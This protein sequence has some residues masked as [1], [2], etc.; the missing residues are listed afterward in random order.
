MNRTFK[1]LWNVVRGQY[2]VVNE[3]AGDAQSRGSG[4][5]KRSGTTGYGGSGF[6]LAALAMAIAAGFSLP[7]QAEDLY[8]DS[9]RGTVERTLSEGTY[10]YGT[11]QLYL[12]DKSL[13]TAEPNVGRDV[14]ACIEFLLKNVQS[15]LNI[16]GA[17]VTTN[18]FYL[19]TMGPRIYGSPYW[20]FNLPVKFQMQSGSLNVTGQAQIEG[21]SY[22]QT[23]G[24][25]VMNAATIYT[26][27]GGKRTGA[28]TDGT[29][30]FSG[31]TLSINSL[32]F[33]SASANIDHTG[34]ELT[35][36]AFDSTSNTN[37]TVKTTG[38]KV[39]FGELSSYGKLVATNADVYAP[40]ISLT[41]QSYTSTDSNLTTGLDQVADLKQM[42]AQ[43]RVLV[44]ANQDEQKDVDAAVL[45]DRMAVT[46]LLEQFENNVTWSGGKFHFTGSYSQSIADK[47]TELIHTAFGDDVVVEFEETTPDI[48]PPSV[49]NGLTAALSNAIISANTMSGGAVFTEYDLDAVDVANT[50]GGAAG[51]Y[52][53][54]TSVG[55]RSVNGDKTVTVTGG[56][57]FA[58]LGE[59][60]GS[61]V[62]SGTLIADNGTLRLGT[63]NTGVT[64]GG[65]VTD[66]DLLNNGVLKVDRGEF[67]VKDVA[68]DGSV[69][70]AAGDLTFEKLDITGSFTNAG[71]ATLADGAKWTGGA[72][73]G[74]LNSKGSTIGG[75]FSNAGG[76]WNLDGKLSFAEDAQVA[77]ATGTLNTDFRNLFDNGTG[78]ELDGLNTVSLNATMPEEVRTI[79]TELFTK[80]VKGTV[81][82]DVLAHMTFDGAG[83]LVITNANLTTTQR[84]DLTKAFQDAFGTSTTIKF[85]GTIEGVSEDSVLNTAK[86]N[87]LAD[88]GFKDIVYI[89]RALQGEAGDVTIGDAGV[90]DSVGFMSIEDAQSVT[91]T[92]GKKLV[93]VGQKDQA[94]FKLVESDQAVKV[95]GDGELVLGSL[96]LEGSE[97]YK[98]TVTAVNVGDDAAGGKFTTVA[99]DY[100]V[101]TLEAKHKDT[102]VS[103]TKDGIL[104]VGALAASS[105]ASVVND[106]TLKVSGDATSTAAS[107][108]NRADMTVEG[109]LTTTGTLTNEKTL[110]V[111]NGLAAEGTMTNAKGGVLDVEGNVTV[112]S[113]GTPGSFTNAGTA[114]LKGDLSVSG[115][116]TNNADAFLE[117]NTMTVVGTL[118]NH[119]DI[120]ASDDSEVYGTLT[121]TGTIDLF[122]TV[123][124]QRGEINNTHSITGQGTITVN[125]LLANV[126]N[127]DF[128]GETLVLTNT[129]AGSQEVGTLANGVATV[130][131]KGEMTFDSITVGAGTEFYNEGTFT[132][133]ELTVEEGGYHFTGTRPTT[134]GIALFA[135]EGATESYRTMTVAG[136]TTNAGNAYYGTLTI[137]GT[138]IYTNAATGALFTGESDMHLD[139]TGLTIEA[140]GTLENAGTATL[141]SSLTN[142]GTI[143]GDGTVTFKRGGT[144]TNVF[145]NTGTISV[146]TFATDGAITYNQSGAAS[147]FEASNGWFTNATVNVEQGEMSHA[148]AGTGN[149]YN[150]G[151]EGA[152]AAETA[153]ITF[154]T[155]DSSNVFNI[156]EGATLDVDTIA[157][158]EAD[159]TVHLLGGTL[160]TTLDQIFGDLR[161]TAA[162]IDAESP[163]DLVDVDGVK[164]VTGVGDIKAPVAQG[165]EF[166]WGTVAF[167]DAVYST[168]LVSDVLTKLDQNDTAIPGHEGVGV[169]GG[170]EVAFNGA[171][172]ET[173]NVDLA[174]KVTARPAG[175][176]EP[177]GSAFAVFTGEL[178]TN[179]TQANGDAGGKLY[180]GDAGK[181]SDANVLDNSMGFK[182]VEGVTGG[183][184]VADGHHFVLV[185]ELASK[186]GDYALVDGKVTVDTDGVLTLGSY[187]TAEKT[188]G[189]L[190][191][192]TVT[193]G[194]VRVRHGDFT[195]DTVENAGSI[196]IGGDGQ[197]LRA[198]TDVSLTVDKY[199]AKAN[200]ELKNYGTFNA[201]ELTSDENAGTITN[202]GLLDVAT[203]TISTALTN[204][205]TAVFDTL[206]ITGNVVTNGAQDGSNEGV[207]LE[208]G[209][210]T[211]ANGSTLRNYAALTAGD[212]TID[213]RVE[214]AAGA[215]LDF[216]SLEVTTNGLLA[217]AGT[218]TTDSITQTG[219]QVQ[220]GG[221]MTVESTAA[222]Q[223]AGVFNNTGTLAIE[224]GEAFTIAEGGSFS[225]AGTMTSEADV[226]VTGGAFSQES[227]TATALVNM[228]VTGGTTTVSA[229]KTLAGSGLFT[230]NAVADAEAVKNDGTIDFA[231]ITV[232]QGKV[233]GDGTFGS[234]DTAEMKVE[235]NGVVDQG[236]V[237]ANY[238][239]NAGIVTAGSMQLGVPS[240][241]NGTMTIEEKLDGRITNNGT[242]TLGG[243]EE[244]FV[245]TS[246]LITNNGTLI[247]SETVTLQGGNITQQADTA[248]VFKDLVIESGRLSVRVL[249]SSVQGE[250]LTVNGASADG[251]YVHNEG[252]VDFDV[253]NVTKGSVTGE[254]TLGVSD[255][256]ITVAADG[257]VDQAKVEGDTLSN[258]GSVVADELLVHTEGSNTGLLDAIVAH[259]GE[260]FEN[261]ADAAMTVAD[262]LTGN[263]TNKGALTFEGENGLS[264]TSGTLTNNGT[265]SATEAVTVAGGNLVHDSDVTATFTDLTI[266]SGSLVNN[267]DRTMEGA[268]LRVEAAD[269]ATNLVTNDGTLDFGNI[270]VAKGGLVGSGTL[271]SSDSTILTGVGGRIEQGNVIA[272]T[273][274]NLGSIS[275][276]VT[277]DNGTNLGVIAANDFTS[278]GENANF[279]NTGT[280]TVAGKANVSGFENHMNAAF[281]QGATFTGTNLSDGT[282]T[283][284][285]GLLDVKDGQ[286]TIAGGTLTVQNGAS[287]AGVLDVQE[288]VTAD[289]KDGLTIVNGGTFATAGNTT[290]DQITS[291]TTGTLVAAGGSLTIGDLTTASGMTFTQTADTTLEVGKGW[292]ENSVINIQ[293]GKFDASL[294]KDDEGNASGML[295]HN[296]VNIGKT[297]LPAVV[298]PDSYLPAADK[299]DW[300]DPYVT[301]KVDT[302]TSDTV[303][304]VGSGGVLDV[305]HIELTPE[306]GSGTTVTIGTGGG[307]QTSL[308]Q[309]F[310]KVATTVTDIEAI[311][312]ETGKVDIVTDVIATTTVTD[313]KDSVQAGLTFE[314]GSMVAWDDEDW[315]IDLVSSVANSLTNA[316]L[317]SDEVRVQQHFLGDFMGDFTV[318][319][320]HRLEEEQLAMGNSHVLDPGVVFDTT[321]LHNVTEADQ[322]A[323][324]GLVIGMTQDEAGEGMNGI[325]Y[326][327]GFK[328]VANA[329]TVAIVNGKEFVLVGTTRP[330]DF[331][332]TTGYTDDNKLLLDS[333]DGGS[334]SVENGT[335]TLGSNGVTNATVGWVNAATVAADGSLV[336][337]NGEFAVWDI[338]NEGKVDVTTG[339]VLHT[340]NLVNENGETHVGGGLTAGSFDNDSGRLEIA[341]GG[342]ADI[343]TLESGTMASVIEN[344]GT[345]VVGEVANGMLAGTIANKGEDS[346]LSIGSDVTIAGWESNEG[347]AFWQ[348]VTLQLGT[349][350]NSGY[351]QGKFLTVSSGTTH[352]NTGTSIWEGMKVDGTSVNGEAITD[353][354]LGWMEGFKPGAQMQVGT[355]DGTGTF[356]VNGS[357][358]NNGLLDAV[359]VENTLVNGTMTNSGQA[360]YDDMTISANGTST[361]AGY[362][363][364]DILT[365][366]GE[367]SNTGVSV[368]NNVTIAQNASSSNGED[369]GDKPNGNEE[370]FT[371]DSVVYVGS[372]AADETFTIDGS[373]V[374]NGIVQAENAEN[375]NVGGTLVNNGQAAYDDMTIGKDG[376]STNVGYEQGDI[377]TVEGSHD[378]T[379]T[380]VWNNVTIA[381][382]GTGSNGFDLGDGPKGDEEG[383]ESDSVLVVGSE[384]VP[385]SLVIE[386]DYV[387][388]GILQAENVSTTDVSGNLT[389]NGQAVYDD[390][391]VNAGGSSVNTG[392]EQGDILTVDGSHENSGT[393]IWNNVTIGTG[394]SGVNGEEL[395]DGPKGHEEGF[396]SDDV[397]VIGS[398]KTDDKF[399]V[400]GD[401]ANH[402]VLDATKTEDTTVTGSLV[403]DGQAH[404]DDMDVVNGGSSDNDGYEKGDILTVGDG[405][406]HTNDGTSIWNN[407]TIGQG[408]SGSNAG[409][410]QIG[411]EGGGDEF[412]VEGDYTNDGSLDATDSE[413]TEVT[414]DLDNNGD[415]H[416]D[417]MDIESGG[418]STNDNYEEGDI[419]DVNEGGTW[420]QNG[421]SHWNN[422]NV[423]GGD[424]DNSG[425]IDV[426]DKIVI[427]DGSDFTNT[428]DITTGELVVD[429][430]VVDIGGGSIDADKTTV[431]GGDIIVGNHKDLSDENRVDFD[432]I[433]DGD[434]NGH[435]WVIGNGDLSFG[436]GADEFADKIGAPDIPEAPSRITVTQNVTVGDTGSIAVGSDVWT[437]ESN[438]EDVGDG[439][440]FF[441][442]DSVTVVDSTILEDGKAAFTG[443]K[444]GATVTVE[445]GA[446]L[447]LGNLDVAG[448]YLITDG[449][450]TAGNLGEADEW[451]GGW[452]GAIWAPTDAGSGLDWVLTLGWDDTKLWVNAKL[453]SVIN[454][455]PDIAIPDNI[456]ESLENC[457]NAGG[458]DDVLVCT[459]IRNPDLSKDDKT[460]ILNSVAEIGH[461]AGAAAMAF[462]EATQAVDSL[463]GRVS[464][465]SEAYNTDGSMKSGTKG[466]ALWVDV[467]G[468][469]TTADSYGATG[470]VTTGYDADSYG[471]IMGADHKLQS[472]NV[473]LGAAFSYTDGSLDSTGDLLPT[474]NDFSTWGIHAYGAW[475]PSER[476]NVIGT[477]S[478][479]RSAS[480]AV[481]GLPAEAGFSKAEADID[482][483][484]FVAGVRGEAIFEVGKA[485]FIP[486]AGLRMVVTDTKG[487]KTKLDGQTAYRNEADTATTFQMPIGVSMRFDH[488]TESG[489]TI[490]PSGDITLT[491][492]FGDTEQDTKVKGTGG[493][494][495]TVTGEFT[496]NF[497]A[498]FSLGLQAESSSNTT[499]GVR[500][501]LTAGQEG[502]QDH[503]LKLEF[504]K[505]F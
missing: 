237:I 150:L 39:T 267:G 431:N 381:Q 175:T 52:N 37:G 394:G 317:I 329:D 111:K 410:I 164:V 184:T 400:D 396:T 120:D 85:V 200:S 494:T 484:L 21:D 233:V 324:T 38:S 248:A 136:Q 100:A 367:H 419:L 160:S 266:N 297:D 353:G 278:T 130:E 275:G 417:D 11:I 208:A 131:N 186:Q 422:I 6:K 166:G 462:N 133:G 322:Y 268:N 277:V 321:T 378:N 408:G 403:N 59:G 262:T 157:L 227:D 414:G 362:E 386:G 127:A 434:L 283:V 4:K 171:A 451:L 173:F 176:D 441:A 457:R 124:G 337:K 5:L 108:Q 210:L 168:G 388:N 1:T 30:H 180:V 2:V 375:T 91:V 99:G 63:T 296:T 358:T 119:G 146:G 32:K 226:N 504:R 35:I 194:T 442:H 416:Y 211:T 465:R 121:N 415:A 94:D 280:L 253:I 47:A 363:Q 89:D 215:T 502:K 147:S 427:G 196:T 342:S 17:D 383:F 22:F 493:A 145:E 505:L 238:L 185:G 299:V 402:G 122:N 466:T 67:V 77:N 24:D 143:R 113:A 9:R 153:T 55:F 202:Y 306:D 467:L 420:D 134:T 405:S 285:G 264:F 368:W 274:T 189:D 64:V 428:G 123:V 263:L 191:D 125:G 246:G 293:G 302:I 487:Y 257:K 339:S 313:V 449:F 117:T 204:L 36:G 101:T 75:S 177:F 182:G 397:V 214:N 294:I 231:N 60:S 72:N 106:G 229:G 382:G 340:N 464:M 501:G 162:D 350:T 495:D 62:A 486:H 473:I 309:F 468:S 385:G 481:Q 349:M 440:L 361:N 384:E 345:L 418:T 326:S 45:G 205:K 435:Y 354:V 61:T 12:S 66:V 198:D 281:E 132:G 33:S 154:N 13:Q 181:V 470:S 240:G 54:D 44:M 351:E 380:S 10:D 232:S 167:D 325:D 16:T 250:T 103:V 499:V 163:D 83:N 311:D 471:F 109:K 126:E 74:T 295:G 25:V 8:L 265:L 228:N 212:A 496:G 446:Q 370:G 76:T 304:N 474:S 249:N 338:A 34:G 379:G 272:N 29:M 142:A 271:G 319:T 241:N 327:I 305:D 453:E 330:D 73:T 273:I 423:N 236:A 80:Y 19:Y 352:T 426:D 82:E 347:T 429:G 447:V 289:I 374:N 223:I 276:N 498:T 92:D 170:L 87:T 183:M 102:L 328:N 20:Y 469:W 97:T 308:D 424:V 476:T 452:D 81:K 364:G 323:N 279:V 243:G 46:K 152:S 376:S 86:V 316:G 425:T 443:T 95:T 151:K 460:R 320:A 244:G 221:D 459:V 187:A 389:N 84:D 343:G 169:D 68:G 247:G 258:A 392:Y 49:V 390:M 192:L 141:A 207:T 430:G 50:V 483:N 372:E 224:A 344:E 217:N 230:V 348:N 137:T 220:Q 56:K 401:Y 245:F 156:Y 3:K 193:D 458:A 158:T 433:L 373:Y 269:G 290:I 432:T 480:E 7:V 14:Q 42:I 40:K 213:G 88:A 270:A 174:N 399:N 307:I 359:W 333:T 149:V 371:S 225:N 201:T 79:L 254:G 491:P 148:T 332:W 341:Q 203:A 336:T 436:E 377:L 360:T 129:A 438:H 412:T 261:A 454:E 172:S 98:G 206:G 404:Y 104:T 252:L 411:G 71:T 485:K 475:K 421:E 318:D 439:N 242:M 331:D 300:S 406:T 255:S 235:K 463:E 216:G 398:D 314:D 355:E 456:D 391:D 365:V 492:Q 118:D 251:Q 26:P 114:T 138:G 488:V 90:R 395:G 78:A 315:S 222:S 490:R 70:V 116:L 413:N 161:Y 287:V 139:G 445:E 135:N 369:L 69:N 478:Y 144:G 31:G 500:Y 291:A 489:W 393:S 497:A 195:A 334:V 259:V 23:G 190:L 444:D 357:F 18:N 472:K 199:V 503:S 96:G 128:T 218:V 197:T 479:L 301:V 298:G 335:F 41:S 292:F 219:G 58:L 239:E 65:T 105:G 346:K 15:R 107:V 312:P 407:V 51:T 209:T 159:K 112:G 178:L 387:N 366:E 409:D 179:T 288:N 165:V 455:Y 110:T 448:D 115:T 284:S 256:A 28:Y 140:G 48:I 155:I 260:A 356:E 450:L 303:I 282:L 482:T 234:T 57:E 27:P 310:E 93:L 53:I 437:D 477:L 461:A 188:K 286:T 43:A